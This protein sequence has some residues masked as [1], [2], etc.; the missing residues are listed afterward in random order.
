M[1]KQIGEKQRNISEKSLANLKRCPKGTSGNPKGRP[2]GCASLTESAHRLLTKEQ[3]DKTFGEILTCSQDR[4][5]PK[6]QWAVEVI[7]RFGKDDFVQQPA[8][9][10]PI[11]GSGAFT[12]KMGDKEVN[13]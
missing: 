9:G 5:H 6:F 11:G 3:A 4:N 7:A 12:F 10:L 1:A 8:E 13:E 2:S